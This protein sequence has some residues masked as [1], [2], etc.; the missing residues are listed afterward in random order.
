MDFDSVTRWLV[1]SVFLLQDF[2]VDEMTGRRQGEEAS[3]PPAPE[4]TQ[5]S[6]KVQQGKLEYKLLHATNVVRPQLKF[7]DHIDN[8]PNTVFMRKITVK[9]HAMVPLDYGKSLKKKKGAMKIVKL[10]Q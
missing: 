3:K 8:S 2:C 1:C 9:P 7:K 5:V 4:L 10:K 6:T